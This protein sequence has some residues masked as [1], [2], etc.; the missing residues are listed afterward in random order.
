MINAETRT[1]KSRNYKHCKKKNVLSFN[2][3]VYKH[4][5]KEKYG[6]IKSNIFMEKNIVLSY[7]YIL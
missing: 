7:S 2:Q 6:A 3:Y 4:N 5:G 1:M